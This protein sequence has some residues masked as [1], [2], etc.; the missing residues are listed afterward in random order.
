MNDKNKQEARISNRDKQTLKEILQEEKS[1][2]DNKLKEEGKKELPTV[3]AP[4]YYR[5]AN[6][7]SY[8]EIVASRFRTHKQYLQSHHLGKFKKGPARPKHRTRRIA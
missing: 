2:K 3:I 5:G 1:T 4:C 8:G 6:P 7:D